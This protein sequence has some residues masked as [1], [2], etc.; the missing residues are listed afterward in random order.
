MIEIEA[1]IVVDRAPDE[2]FAFLADM[3]QNPRWQKGMRECRWTSEPPVRIGST[4]DQVARFLG[5]EIKSSFVV[6]EL[7]PGRRIRIRTTSG[8]M[9]IGVTREVQPVGDNRSEVRAVVTGD[10]TRVFRLASPLM[11][12][13]VGRSVARDYRRLKELLEEDTG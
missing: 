11:R 2:V 13:M 12:W 5:K 8:T 4:Y 9:P 10:P 3:S 6:T 7:D 1:G